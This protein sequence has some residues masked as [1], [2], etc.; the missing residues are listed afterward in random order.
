M[1]SNVQFISKQKHLFEE[2]NLQ[3]SLGIEPRVKKTLLTLLGLYKCNHGRLSQIQTKQ[4]R[5][6][7]TGNRTR[8]TRVAG[9]YS[10]T[11]PPMLV[12][13]DSKLFLPLFAFMDLIPRQ[14]RKFGRSLID[15]LS[16]DLISCLFGAI[17]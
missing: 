8:V 14:E 10:T 4:K 1:F 5:I 6:A 13:S 16:L 15:V 2:K 3:Y 7:S 11:R 9:E 12:D 17:G